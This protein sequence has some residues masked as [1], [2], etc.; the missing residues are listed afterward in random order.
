MGEVLFDSPVRH[1]H[2]D[3]VYG[4]LD[5]HQP[6][7]G[8]EQLPPVQTHLRYISHEDDVGEDGVKK[9]KIV[10]K[11]ALL[12][13]LTAFSRSTFRTNEQS[14]GME[15]TLSPNPRTGPPSDTGA[16]PARVIRY[17]CADPPRPSFVFLRGFS[18]RVPERVLH[19]VCL[20]R[21]RDAVP[22]I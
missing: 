4:H 1:V 5:N 8:I 20:R 14:L 2:L 10:Q 18:Q 9:E 16:P 19:A 15:Q 21:S 6:L 17:A 13:F 12:C 22:D 3:Q 11:C 7:L